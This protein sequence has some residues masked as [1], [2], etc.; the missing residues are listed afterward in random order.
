MVRLLFALVVAALETTAVSLPLTALTTFAPPWAA[1][2]VAVAIG[3]LADRVAL[4]LPPQAERPALLVG[5][6]VAAAWLIGRAL[7]VGPLGAL[8]ALL[9]GGASAVAAY[10]TLLLALFLFWRG[11]RLDTRDSAAVGALFG[12]GSAAA[13]GGLVLGAIAGTGLPLGHPAI[14]GQAV[15]LVALGLM[16]LALAHAQEVGDGGLGGL[17]WRWLLT[18]LAAVGV[19]VLLATLA[20]GLLGGGEAMAAAQNLL[21]LLLLPFAIVGGALV[22][23][24]VTFLAEPLRRLIEAILAQLQGIQPPPQPEQSPLQEQSAATAMAT[25]EQIASGA[26]F[27]M[28][29]IPIIILLVA[30]LAMR[31]RARPRPAGDEERESLDLLANLRGDLRDLLAGLHNPFRRPLTGLRAAL[32]ALTGDDPATRTRRAYVRLLLLLEGRRQ[33][34]PPAATPAEFAPAAAAATS[35]ELVTRLTAAYEQA[36][37]NPAGPTPA[38]AAQAEDAL[39]EIERS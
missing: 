18:L 25:I 36:R 31:R 32:A 6:L 33:P 23:L 19:V 8:A 13:V 12:R 29:L 20:T 14:L 35:P 5:A 9:P 38:E 1:L 24:L 3:W 27:L 4:R 39:R 22:W 16:A 17:S 28:A 21:R 26:T 34:R 30:I 15:A 10:F 7:G 2:F 11:T 37:Y